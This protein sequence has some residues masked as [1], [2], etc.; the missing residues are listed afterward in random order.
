[1]RK[2][3][4]TAIVI[5]VLT[6]G[7]TAAHGATSVQ[8]PTASP[9]ALNAA[10]ELMRQPWGSLQPMIMAQAKAGMNGLEI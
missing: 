7:G 2:F 3:G 4:L 10:N 1:M 8:I 5:V 9:A 6:T